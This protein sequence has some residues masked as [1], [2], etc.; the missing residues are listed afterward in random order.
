LANEYRITAEIIQHLPVLLTAARAH[1][2]YSIRAA[3]EEIGIGFNTLYRMEKGQDGHTTRNL[4]AVILWLADN[5][6]CLC[7]DA[8][9]GP[10]C[11][12]GCPVCES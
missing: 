2:G 6:S 4:L 1:Y 3:A 9:G 8:C 12:P 10:W 11:R 5:Y 7:I